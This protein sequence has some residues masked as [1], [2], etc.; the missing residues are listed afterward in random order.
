MSKKLSKENWGMARLYSFLDG[1]PKHDNDLRRNLKGAGS[2][3]S[4]QEQLESIGIKPEAYLK[5]AKRRAK[6]AGLNYKTLRFADTGKHKLTITNMSGSER[7][8]GRIGYGDHLI[9][10]YLEATKKAPAGEAASRRDRFHK[11]HSKIKGDW[12]KD[13]Y[14]PNNLALKVIW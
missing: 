7:H 10:T 14:S 5:E 13:P 9:W 1:N 11:S 3:G 4:F 2:V 8:F 6:K 12:K